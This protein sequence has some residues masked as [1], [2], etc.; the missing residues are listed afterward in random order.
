MP[1]I[2]DIVE[3]KTNHF[4]LI[5]GVLSGTCLMF[6]L[7]SIGLFFLKR[8]HFDIESLS[9]TIV[10]F[11]PTLLV[12]LF[13]IFFSLNMYGWARAGVNN[14]LI[15]EIN[16]RDRLNAVQ[17]GCVGAGLLLIW[18]VFLWT[19][20]LLSSNL[21]A[22]SYRPFVNY[23]P[24]TLDALFLLIAVFPFKGTALWTTKKFFWKLLLRE[25]KAGFI[26]VAFVDFWF[27]DQLNSL[28]QVFLDFEQTLCL[29]ATNKINLSFVPD[30]EGVSD[31][32]NDPAS[33]GNDSSPVFD[34]IEMCSSSSVD[35][36]FRVIFWILPAYIRFAQCIRRA[37][38]S[39]KR[40]GH[41]LQNAAKYSTSFLKVA[42]AY[43]Y[44]YSG[45]DSTAFAF[46]IVANIIASLFTLFWDLK[47]DWGLF[48]LKKVRENIK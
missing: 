26:P 22:L 24:I 30:P 14:I 13:L 9:R 31:A 46:W 41:H 33:F 7:A 42:L 12:A 38:D 15:F 35:Y 6:L 48:N 45:K 47:M 29:L 28:G 19:F 17:M 21:V 39:P 34:K 43:A 16:P 8:A 37:I 36:G 40:R 10:L 27:A 20:L 44:A 32:L 4:L 1:P 25:V 23:I 18:L 2:T 11:R 3:G 5:F